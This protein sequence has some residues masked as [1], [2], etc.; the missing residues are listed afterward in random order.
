MTKRIPIETVAEA[1]RRAKKELPEPVYVSILAGVE[2]GVTL[3]L[4]VAIF[5]EIGFR[6]RIGIAIPPDRKLSTS[7]L[8]QDISL[9]VI[10]APA[11]VQG[12]WPGGEIPVA[13][14]A[15]EAGTAIALSNF[16]SVP[17][18]SVAAANPKAFLQL[19]WSGT[20][21]EIVQRVETARKAAAKALIL[22]LDATP[23]WSRDWGSP[24]IPERINLANAIKFAPVALSR[25]AWLLRFL[26]NGGIPDMRVPNLATPSNPK[27]TMVEGVIGWAQTP[28]P[29]WQDLQ[30]LREL[31]GGPFMVKGVTHPDDARRAVDIGATAISVST[32]GG[33]NLDTTP[34]ALHALP[35]VVRA[36][37][38]Q[39][40]VLFDS[41]PRRGGDVAKALALGARAVLIGRPWIFG[42]AADGERG[43]R[44][45][46]EIFRAGIDNT[47]VSLGHQ[48]IHDLSPDDLIIPDGFELPTPRSRAH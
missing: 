28:R 18:E 16:A 8:G 21:D 9:P 32:H 24:S 48:S 15:A 23:Y 11:G 22:T 14:A 1:Q 6:P 34:A 44:E 10:I 4:N 29:T 37:G 20:R 7:V 19:Y 13:K 12:V 2:K 31:W 41:G 39:I 42:L 43:V 17:F 5:D 46:L 35:A 47:L 27:L 33:N 38:A 26:L 3:D 45:V 36:V 30:W 25:P 40:E